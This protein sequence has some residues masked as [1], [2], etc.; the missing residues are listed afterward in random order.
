[1]LEHVGRFHHVVIDTDEDEV[2]F[3]HVGQLTLANMRPD[4]RVRYLAPMLRPVDLE[5][6][7]GFAGGMGI[8]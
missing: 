4:S 3:A 8:A 2:F 6:C 5:V 7:S 1:M